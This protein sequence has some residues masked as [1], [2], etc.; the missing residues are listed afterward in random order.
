MSA[1]VGAAARFLHPASAKF[2]DASLRLVELRH[3][4][5]GSSRRLQTR[6]ARVGFHTIDPRLLCDAA[7]EMVEVVRLIARAIRC[8]EW[9]PL[10][11]P[12]EVQELQ[13]T[14]GLGAQ[15][16][17]E[18][19]LEL[20]L[21]G[22]VAGSSEAV[23]SIKTRAAMLY[24]QGIG[25]AFGECE[26]PLDVLRQRTLDDALFAVVTGSESA[27]AALRDASAD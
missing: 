26:D 17:A 8:R 9:L 2:A 11:D 6:L 20:A 14:A 27:L 1:S 10:S 4:I 25:R 24:D 19:A 23:D 7:T 13:S 16:V 22:A 5:A 15:L 12:D 18:S 3:E 21:T